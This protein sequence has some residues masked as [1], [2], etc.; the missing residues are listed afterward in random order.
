MTTTNLLLI[1]FS[2]TELALLVVVAA[3]FIRL[4]KSEALVQTLQSKQ[5]EFV[6]KLHF[7]AQ[8]EQELMETFGKRQAQL[9]ELDDRMQD[10]ARELGDLVKH[11]EAFCR[12]PKFLRQVILAGHKDGKSARDLAKATGL[13]LEEVELIL[14]QSG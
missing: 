12:S 5:Q 14:Q 7:N 1:F 11:A 13:S 3:F 2:I 8:L 9:A 6:N 4:K 10:R